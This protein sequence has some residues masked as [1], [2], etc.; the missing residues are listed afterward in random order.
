M[1]G[2]DSQER[3][4]KAGKV[5][6]STRKVSGGIPYGTEKKECS[7]FGN[8]DLGRDAIVTK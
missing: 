3:A 8:G 4:R 1:I 5:M 7:F 2:L 6:W